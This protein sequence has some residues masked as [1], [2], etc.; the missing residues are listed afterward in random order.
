MEAEPDEDA[1]AG[2]LCLRAT[3]GPQAELAAYL[4]AEGL[5]SAPIYESLLE[6]ELRNERTG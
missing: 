2:D 4:V 1:P 6:R 3:I 5:G